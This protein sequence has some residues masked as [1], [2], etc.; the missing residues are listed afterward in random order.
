MQV[1][2]NTTLAVVKSIEQHFFLSDMLRSL[3]YSLVS[4]AKS[5]Q[6]LVIYLQFACLLVCLLEHVLLTFQELLHLLLKC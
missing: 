1:S 3:P 5:S 4:L 2:V 6:L